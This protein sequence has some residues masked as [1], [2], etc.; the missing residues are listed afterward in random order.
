MSDEEEEGVRRPE[1]PF[2]KTDRDNNLM[3]KWQTSLPI[4]YPLWDTAFPILPSLKDEQI[5]NRKQTIAPW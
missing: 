1:K 3:M 5:K 4:V 2:V